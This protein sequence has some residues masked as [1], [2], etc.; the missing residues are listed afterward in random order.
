MSA[1][2]LVVDDDPSLVNLLT[3]NLEEQGY[4]IISGYDGQMAIVQAK[5]QQPDLIIMD[6]NMPMTNGL[7]AMAAIRQNP[8]TQAIPIILLTG[9]TSDRVFPKVE[10][11][12]RVMHVKKP[13]DLDEL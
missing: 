3:A 1:M 9:E 8:G 11:A 6:V 4:T 10:D 12:S 2:I 7:R 5:T 13:V